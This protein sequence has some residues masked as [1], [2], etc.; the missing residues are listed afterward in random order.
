MWEVLFVNF[1]MFVAKWT[2]WK[3][4]NDIKYNN[5]KINTLKIKQMLKIELKSNTALITKSLLLNENIG[6]LLYENLQCINL[7]IIIFDIIS[8]FPYCPFSYKH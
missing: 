3:F 6:K 2:I 7:F 5:K 4:R 1:L 8:K